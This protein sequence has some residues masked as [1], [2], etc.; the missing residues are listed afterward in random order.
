[1]KRRTTNAVGNYFRKLGW[2]MSTVNARTVAT[3]ALLII[4]ILI[5]VGRIVGFESDH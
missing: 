3:D 1:M 5:L 2:F 4:A